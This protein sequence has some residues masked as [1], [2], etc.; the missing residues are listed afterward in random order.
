[1]HWVW[2]ES[3]RLLALTGLKA[4]TEPERSAEAMQQQKD[5]MFQLGTSLKAA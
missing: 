1:L 5:W 4:A 3:L 2:T